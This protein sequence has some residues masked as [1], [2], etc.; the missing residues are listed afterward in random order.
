MTYQMYPGSFADADGDGT[1]DLAG[2][3]PRL[4]HLADLG[5]DAIWLSPRPV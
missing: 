3:T 2:I 1:G 4:D 5:V